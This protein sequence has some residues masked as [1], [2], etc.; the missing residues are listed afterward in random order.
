MTPGELHRRNI[1]AGFD[2]DPA[3]LAVV[4]RLDALHRQLAAGSAAGRGLGR[5]LARRRPP[6]RGM[7]LWGSVGRGKTYLMD[8]LHESVPGDRL[9]LHFHRFMQRVHAELGRFAGNPD[10]LHDVADGIAAEARLLCFDEFFVSDIGDAMILAEL[11][12]HLFARQVTLV[13]TSNVEPSHLYDNGLQRRRFLPA[14]RLIEQH[15]DVVAIGGE[16]D[17]RL[18]VL[19]QSEIYRAATDEAGLERSFRE[20]CPGVAERDARL[21]VNGRS[22]LARQRGEDVVWFEFGQICDGPR[23]Q[24][25]YIELAREFHAVVVSGVPVFT[26]ATEDQARR[27]ISLIDEFYDRNV[28]MLLSAHAP[29]ERLY[30]GERLGFE[31]QRTESRIIEMQGEEYLARTH[32]A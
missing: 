14:I 6:V 4:E 21:Q 17:F 16:V 32:R 11:L 9:R 25:D 18:R 12:S 23:S 28:K 1:D 8:L 31:F 20:L 22:I 30:Q 2:A 7:Y 15:C 27:F 26:P 13:A 29:V 19:R 5:L 10:P 24:N 3:Q